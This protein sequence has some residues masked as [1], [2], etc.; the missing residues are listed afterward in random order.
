MHQLID[1]LAKTNILSKEEFIHLI[2]H[3]NA[4]ISEY[5]FAKAREAREKYYG[6]DI[7]I[8]GLIEITNYCKNDCYYCGI[9]KSNKNV[10]RYRLTKTQILDCCKKGYVLGFRTFV[11]QGGDDSYY[12]D[13]RMFDIV[14]S[15]KKLYPD[16]AI[17]LSLGEKTHESFLMLFKA[18]ADRYL[19]RHETSDP[20][21]YGKLHPKKMSSEERKRCLYD[22]KEIG[23]QVGSG[24]M[25]GTPFQT[26]E[27][28]A[29]DLLF[30]VD[31]QPQMVGIG[32]FIS[33]HETPFAEKT[34]GTLELTLFMLA[35]LRLILPSALLPSTTAL[36]TID[37]EGREQGILAGANVVMPNLSPLD[38]RKKY[39]IYDN[40]IGTGL[41]SSEYLPM[42]KLQMKKL[43]YNVVVARGD[44]K[45]VVK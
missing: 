17:T 9:R 6:K 40:K 30:I 10:L 20:E 38:V 43:G 14:S 7:Y 15:I 41:E 27:N 2:S 37:N 32:P 4:E 29:E 3:R 16:C 39:M 44:Y 42:L 35:L 36:G 33:H 8:R 45:P 25:V 12:N 18:G 22:L 1:K 5:L 11:L 31:L 34:N 28:L 23:Y 24:F 21:H 26:I 13:N 19:L